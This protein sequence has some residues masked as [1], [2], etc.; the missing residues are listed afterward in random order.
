MLKSSK[1]IL[2]ELIE[3]VDGR[4]N[5]W[6]DYHEMAARRLPDS[7]R[8]KHWNSIDNYK[9]LSKKLK[10]SLEIIKEENN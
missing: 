8:E 1:E 2:T 5:A 10:K 9:E 6:I 7:K 3:S 4:L